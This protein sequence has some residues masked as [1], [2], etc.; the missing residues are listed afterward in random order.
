MQA[1]QVSNSIDVAESSQLSVINL[2]TTLT[3][4]MALQ[5]QSPCY[6]LPPH[7]RW[8]C[9]DVQQMSITDIGDNHC[10]WRWSI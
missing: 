8:Q 5:C 1:L 4:C 10:W 2:Q 7:P 6:S 3:I 9:A